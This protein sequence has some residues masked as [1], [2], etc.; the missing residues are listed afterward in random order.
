PRH[1]P[2]EYRWLLRMRNPRLHLVPQDDWERITELIFERTDGSG[3]ERP[4]VLHG[5]LSEEIVERCARAGIDAADKKVQAAMF[6]VFKS[7]A[8]VC[9]EPGHEGSP[10]FHWSL[11]ARLAPDVRSAAD[12]RQR[13]LRYLAVL[14][15]QRMR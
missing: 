10:D 11:P 13:A 1:T 14:L 2:Y 7:G 15:L 8:F 4:A 9:A 12:L 6:Q 3:G 5:T